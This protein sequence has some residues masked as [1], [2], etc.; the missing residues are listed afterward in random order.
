[1][2]Y[3]A[4]GFKSYNFVLKS[5]YH[6]AWNLCM[7]SGYEFPLFC[8]FKQAQDIGAKIKKGAAGIPIV[9]WTK[10]ESKTEKDSK[11]K[12]K[13]FSM[14]KY[15]TVFN[16]Q[17]MEIPETKHE[18][19]MAWYK[20]QIKN[21]KEVKAL[22]EEMKGHIEKYLTREGIEL[23][24][25]G[26]RAF[27]NQTSD[28]IRMPKI[29]DFETIN[30]YFSTI[31]HEI[32]HSTGC[33]KRLDRP[34]FEKRDDENYGK[35][36]LIAELVSCFSCKDFGVFTESEEK[37]SAAYLKSWIDAFK[38]EPKMLIQSMSYAQKA[39]KFIKDE[40]EEKESEEITE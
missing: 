22:P 15:Y 39:M 38:A 18:K 3:G 1:M 10:I 23:N 5:S 35:E 21:D 2:T 6:G 12:P 11:G 30:S 29:E 8:S 24:H 28:S 17:D 27:Y 20:E 37:N 9:F 26:N 40:R 25:G 32:G 13:T 16:I 14:L 33:K 31:M 7:T 34:G 4:D 36:E 19:I